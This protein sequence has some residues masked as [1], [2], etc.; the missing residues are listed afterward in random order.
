M[1][2]LTLNSLWLPEWVQL[3]VTLL[4]ALPV[5]H[6]IGRELLQGNWATDLIAAV[7]IV[8]GLVT[9]QYLVA[10]IIVVMVT[11]GEIL[12]SYA[13]RRA[14]S[15]LSALAERMPT[16]AHRVVAGGHEDVAVAEVR[17]GDRLLIFPH[18]VAPA[19]GVVRRGQGRMD[20]SFLT[21]EPW[22]VKKAPG[23]EVISGARNGESLLEIEVLRRPEDSRY[24]QIMGVMRESEMKR[25]R[26]R[27]LADQLGAWYSPV[28]LLLAAAAGW[29][30]QDWQRFLAVIVVATPC[31][32]LISIPVALIGAVSRAARAGIVIRD[33]AVLEEIPRV[34]T[35]IF[36]KTGTLTRGRPKLVGVHAVGEFGEAQVLGWLASL[37]RYSKHPLGVAVLDE[38]KRRGLGMRDAEAVRE[39]PGRGLTATMEGV[40]F[41][42]TARKG[43]AGEL[44]ELPGGHLE[45]LLWREGVV[46]GVFHFFD[47]PRPDTRLFLDHLRP[48]HGGLRTVLLTGDQEAPARQLAE[49]VGIEEVVA[50]QSPEQKLEFVRAAV[51]QGPTLYVGDGI[52]DGPALAAATVGVAFGAGSAVTGAAASALVLEAS[53]AKID[54]LLHLGIRLRRI[55]L[56]STVGG[57]GLSVVGMGLAAYGVLPPLYGALLQE[58]IDVVSVLNALRTTLGDDPTDYSSSSFL[59]LPPEEGPI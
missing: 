15:A 50:H 32:L 20:E 24:A 57:L 51:K 35:F 47:A 3:T 56:Q 45:C 30:V 14:A 53:L 9:G 37:E 28:A 38:A 10:L 19:D 13:V 52:N 33:P 34:R 1:D 41:R 12:E 44:P 23:V 54:E 48:R 31:P 49:Q 29:W 46:I 17:V 40:E 55:A 8:T 25:P 42:V 2:T 11:G 21:G 26:I 4:A 22:E 39:E 59:A 36:D 6:R 7:S 16:V 27:R 5:L 43:Y 58:A 18:E